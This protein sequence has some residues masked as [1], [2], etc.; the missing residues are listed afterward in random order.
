VEN[1]T[2]CRTTGFR[3]A[4]SCP[5]KAN[6]LMTTGQAPES[7]CPWHGGDVIAANNDPNAPQLL[8]TTED[9]TLVGQYQLAKAWE[10]KEPEIFEPI[11]IPAP[12][13]EVQF[14]PYKNDPAPADEFERRYQELLKQYNIM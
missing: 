9:E 14:E 1:V 6:I 2:I 12:L 11:D 4:K 3:A 13:P 5:N 8:L 7:Y 10:E